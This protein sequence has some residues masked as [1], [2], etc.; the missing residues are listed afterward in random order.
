MAT[1]RVRVTI[2]DEEQPAANQYS[3]HHPLAAEAWRSGTLPDLPFPGEFPLP[4]L[5]IAGG[6]AHGV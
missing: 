3:R 6:S 2:H 4:L 5:W 1:L